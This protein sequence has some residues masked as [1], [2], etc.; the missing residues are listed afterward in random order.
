MNLSHRLYSR[1]LGLQLGPRLNA[2]KSVFRPGQRTPVAANTSPLVPN[3]DITTRVETPETCAQAQY[4]THGQLLARQ[5]RWDELARLIAASDRQRL[6]TPGATSVVDLLAQGARGDAMEVA[7]DAA[8]R[9]DVQGTKAALATLDDMQA[10]YPHDYGIG[11]VVAQAHIEIGCEWRGESGPEEILTHRL[12]AFH[13]HFRT[14][15]RIINSFDPFELDAPSLAAARCALLVGHPRPAPRVAD[16]YE[17]II[18]FDPHNPNHMRNLGNYLLPHW[19]G[20][21][22]HLELEARRTAARTRDIWGA[23]AY[24]WVYFDALAVDPEAFGLLDAEYF[25]EGLHDIVARCSDQ[26]TINLLAA[27]TGFTLAQS[28]APVDLRDR[29]SGCFDWIVHDHLRELHPVV[30][31]AALPKA[32]TNPQ[33]GNGEIAARG[34]ARA[35]SS[36]AGHFAS[37]IE[38]DHK[39]NFEQDCLRIVN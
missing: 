11:L 29:I 18:D 36:L 4:R 10:D 21:Y 39:D 33:T 27:F 15:A 17:D 1:S 9:D 31:A 38:H 24:V 8:R 12:A 35:M 23:G 20:S 22:E 34:R 30:W 6:A 16:D 5:G 7:R 2:L 14:A 13:A 32:K 26:H 25:V 28:A 3:L 37:E 19:F